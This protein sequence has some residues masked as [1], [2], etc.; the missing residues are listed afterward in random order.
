MV[1]TSEYSIMNY[2]TKYTRFLST[3]PTKPKHQSVLCFDHNLFVPK[4]PSFLHEVTFVCILGWKEILAISYVPNSRS[5]DIYQGDTCFVSSCKQ[6]FV[7]VFHISM[8][9]LVRHWYSLFIILIIHARFT[10]W[11]LRYN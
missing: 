2:N 6:N 11:Y 7:L 9:F 5:K 1:C 4:T 8:A 3:D 10:V